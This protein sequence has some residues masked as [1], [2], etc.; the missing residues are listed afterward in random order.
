MCQH[1][2][3]S[4][5][6]DCCSGEKQHHTHGEVQHHGH[7]GCCEGHGP[8]QDRY[9]GGDDCG[10]GHDRHFRRRFETREERVARLEEYLHALKAE[11]KA[12]EEQ[13]AAFKT[14]E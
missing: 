13:I 4:G 10:C 3:H 1:G 7:G 9:G 12:V 14:V 8:W 6:D 11:A 5:H 2:H